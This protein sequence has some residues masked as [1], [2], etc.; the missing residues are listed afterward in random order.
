MIIRPA[1]TS[2]AAAILAIYAPAV[3][4]SVIS[5]EEEVPT[6]DQI[7]GRMTSRPAMPWLVAQ[8]DERDG[9]IAGYAYGSQHRQRAAY[10]WA[11]DCSVYLAPHYHRRGIGTLLYKALFGELRDLGY[12][13][14]YAGITLPNDASVGL[15]EHLGFVPVGVYRNVGFK[16]G[17]WLD[18]GWWTM[19]LVD[20]LPAAPADPTEWAPPQ[21]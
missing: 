15:H 8:D 7:V 9:E 14:M 6:V 18:V 5:F 21:A 10:R 1:S 16:H 3:T 11:A 12:L 13:S 4:D 17:R 19:P 2:D 20:N